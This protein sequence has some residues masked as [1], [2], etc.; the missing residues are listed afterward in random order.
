MRKI[1]NKKISHLPKPSPLGRIEMREGEMPEGGKL[2]FED[3]TIQTQ[4]YER[5]LVK[6]ITFMAQS[7]KIQRPK[8]EDMLFVPRHAHMILGSLRTQLL[9]PNIEPVVPDEA[10]LDESSSALDTDNEAAIFQQF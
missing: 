4:N 7:G 5:T 10:S 1:P 3:V 8:P 6:S 2:S 9:Y